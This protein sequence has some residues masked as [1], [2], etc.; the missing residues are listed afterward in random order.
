MK[1]FFFGKPWETRKHLAGGL[2]RAP[3]RE[4]SAFVQRETLG[5]ERSRIGSSSSTSTDSRGSERSGRGYVR[6][7]LQTNIAMV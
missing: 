1:S 4:V 3:R 7:T 5:A 2:G 6:L